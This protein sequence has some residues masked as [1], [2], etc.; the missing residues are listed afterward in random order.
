MFKK[1]PASFKALFHNHL[2]A[3]APSSLSSYV[4][5]EDSHTWIASVNTSA[6]KER[7]VRRLQV[8]Q[9][10]SLTVSRCVNVYAAVTSVPQAGGQTDLSVYSAQ[11]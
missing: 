7:T 9:S 2:A 5:A 10:G 6:N 11:L 3:V 1:E 4:T 8:S